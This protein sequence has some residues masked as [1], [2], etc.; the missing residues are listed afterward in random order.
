[1]PNETAE[2]FQQL[3]M[4]FLCPVTGTKDEEEKLKVNLV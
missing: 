4:E 3:W 2:Q 1:M